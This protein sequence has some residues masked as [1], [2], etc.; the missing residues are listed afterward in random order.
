MPIFV[1]ILVFSLGTSLDEKYGKLG[2]THCFILSP[3]FANWVYTTELLFFCIESAR[4]ILNIFDKKQRSK[5]KPAK[6]DQFIKNFITC[7][8]T[9]SSAKNISTMDSSLQR[10]SPSLLLEP[11]FTKVGTDLIYGSS[12]WKMQLGSFQPGF[13]PTPTYSRIES[14]EK[15]AAS[16]SL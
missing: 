16:K 5:S 3:I 11:H 2:R 15:S 10:S 9:Y 14:E 8:K 7:K 4:F 12:V 13:G 6:R 1:V